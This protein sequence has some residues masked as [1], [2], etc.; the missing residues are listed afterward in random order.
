MD[1][2]T[3]FHQTTTFYHRHERWFLFALM[4]LVQAA[5]YFTLNYFSNYFSTGRTTIGAIGLQLSLDQQL[6]FLSLF[7]IPYLTM[8]IVESWP[9]F[10]IKDIVYLRRVTWAYLV[11][12]IVTFA[13]FAFFPVKMLRPEIIPKTFLDQGVLFIYQI[14]LPYNTFPSLHASLTFL[15][16]LVIWQVHKVKGTIVL[17]LAG[18]ISISTLFVKQ[19]YVADVLGGMVLAGVVYLVFQKFFSSK[20]MP[21]NPPTNPLYA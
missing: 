11:V 10:I 14:D 3:T 5:G 19:H 12:M 18:L 13:V 4:W 2:T 7:L 8:Y 21:T 6:P 17:L 15:A 1:L 20:V 16:G 9:Y